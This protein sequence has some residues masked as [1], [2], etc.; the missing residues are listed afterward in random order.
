MPIVCI[1]S[2]LADPITD[3]DIKALVPDFI[4]KD[5]GIIAHQL[6]LLIP[7]DAKIMCSP[8]KRAIQTTQA[9]LPGRHYE[10]L[11]SLYFHSGVE[12]W[13]KVIDN[14]KLP[15][16]PDNFLSLF[17]NGYDT[18]ILQFIEEKVIPK[19]LFAIASG[20]WS[21]VVADPVECSLIGLVVAQRLKCNNFIQFKNRSFHAGSVLFLHPKAVPDVIEPMLYV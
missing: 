20:S 14:V 10:I 21:V 19:L 13:E 18:Y 9:L 7:K 11:E 12:H 17:K 15:V 2:L 6:S 3:K 5:C 1:S 4:L 16:N 8:A